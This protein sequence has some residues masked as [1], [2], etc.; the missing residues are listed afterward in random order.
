MRLSAREWILALAGEACLLAPPLMLAGVHSPVRAVSALLLFGLAPG[1]AALPLL[2]PRGARV[3]LVLVIA[4]SLAFCA[5]AAQGMLWLHAW[6]L[7][8]ATCVL[9]A[10]CALSIAWQLLAPRE[11]R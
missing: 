3:E 8:V 6:N 4:S 5:V 1:A 7:M 9:A 11:A 2:G 10:G